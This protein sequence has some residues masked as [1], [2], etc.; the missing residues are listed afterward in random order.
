MRLLA[1]TIGGNK[2]IIDA[3]VNS[4]NGRPVG[5]KIR[6]MFKSGWSRWI[7]LGR[8]RLVK[9]ELQIYA[10]SSKYVAV[11]IVLQV[12][13]R[14]VISTFW[15]KLHSPKFKSISVEIFLSMK[16][17]WRKIEES[18]QNVQELFITDVG[19]Y[20]DAGRS[21]NWRKGIFV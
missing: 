4:P 5:R 7:C 19:M 1:D 13:S 10:V 16:A 8:G 20:R 14:L 11:S 9:K 2:N 15:I 18:P 17:D 12:S 21:Q 3:G 6:P